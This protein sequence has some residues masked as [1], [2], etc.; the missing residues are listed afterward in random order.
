M[1]GPDHAAIIWIQLAFAM[2]TQIRAAFASRTWNKNSPVGGLRQMQQPWSR[3]QGGAT[4]KRHPIHL[5]LRF[6]RGQQ[7]VKAGPYEGGKTFANEASAQRLLKEYTGEDFGDDAEAWSRWIRQNRWVYD[8]ELIDKYHPVSLCLRRLA[9][10]ASFQ[11]TPLPTSDEAVTYLRAWS[12]AEL[13]GE[14]DAWLDWIREQRHKLTP[15][16]KRAEP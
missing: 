10:Q 1:N 7:T 5:A 8:R 11:G 13:S 15:A 9:G 4:L 6:L 3:R 16:W 14:L 12:G 2:Q